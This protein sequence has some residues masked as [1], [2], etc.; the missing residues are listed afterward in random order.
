MT[1]LKQQEINQLLKRVFLE[2]A[3][4]LLGKCEAFLSG[5]VPE[6]TASARLGATFRLAQTLNASALELGVT[7]LIEPS[8]VFRDSLDVVRV[9]AEK[10]PAP[11]MEALLA[12]VA[13]LRQSLGSH[14][15]ERPSPELTG[16]MNR[17]VTLTT[18]FEADA[19]KLLQEGGLYGLPIGIDTVFRTVSRGPQAKVVLTS[20][21]LQIMSMLDTATDKTIQRNI[22]V[23]AVWGDVR[24]CTKTFGVHMLNLRR[25][26][27][28]LGLA[29]RFVPP[30]LYR[31]V[32]APG[33][34][35]VD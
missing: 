20:K 14:G 27:S 34:A 19:E 2:E 24:C 11:L 1:G 17:L 21:E 30:D 13:S 31:L 6:T 29:I 35:D 32:D 8:R 4:L 18:E 33:E 15:E 12:M 9:F 16:V 28:P 26:I 7:S 10:A 25:K 22:L 23:S 3:A 5:Q